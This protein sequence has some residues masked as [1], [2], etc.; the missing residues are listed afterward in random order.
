MQ[1]HYMGKTKFKILYLATENTSNT[2][3]R[4]YND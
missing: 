4:V 3:G 2:V 1:Y